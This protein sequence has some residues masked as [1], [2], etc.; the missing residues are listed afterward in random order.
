MKLALII[1]ALVLMYAGHVFA[2]DLVSEPTQNPSARYRLFRTQNIHTL[3]KLDTR[4]GKIWQVQWGKEKERFVT[5]ISL[6]VLASGKEGLFTLYPT[7]NI[8]TFLLLDQESG[9]TWQ[10][11]WGLD[12]EHRFVEP[13]E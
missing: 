10:V 9:N 2:E 3:L 6:K 1:A 12:D 13:V 4:T 7:P 8:Y 5:V 11:Q